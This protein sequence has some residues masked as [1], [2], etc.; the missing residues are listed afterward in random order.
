[1]AELIGFMQSSAGRLIRIIV[2][3]ALIAL[4]AVA[5]QPPASYVVMAIGLVP[6]TAGLVG[7]CF[8]GPLVGYTLMG[9]RRAHHA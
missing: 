9:N 5:L 8:I 7:V 1:M 6:F 4:G 2:G 3:L